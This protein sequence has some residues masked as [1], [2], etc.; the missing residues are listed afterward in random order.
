MSAGTEFYSRGCT[1][2]LKSRFH[3]DLI[4]YTDG[5]NSIKI[6]ETEREIRRRMFWFYYEYGLYVAFVLV[7]FRF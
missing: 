5:T 3:E 1:L 4:F 7:S 6:T 2:L